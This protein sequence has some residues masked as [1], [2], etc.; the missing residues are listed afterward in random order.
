MT[1]IRHSAAATLMV[2]LIAGQ[3][4]GSGVGASYYV[5]GKVPA[6]VKQ[7]SCESGNCGPMASCQ[8]CQ[9][10]GFACVDHATVPPCTAE[11]TC[12][13][14]PNWGWH[15]T[16]WR[17]WPGTE[18]TPSQ[19]PSDQAEDRLIPAYE[20]PRPEVE[21]QQAPPPIEDEEEES[22]STTDGLEDFD[23]APALPGEAGRPGVEINLPPM[24]EGPMPNPRPVAPGFRDGPPGLPFGMSPQED[25]ATQQ[26]AGWGPPKPSFRVQPAGHEVRQSGAD[27]PPPLPVG[28]TRKSLRKSLRRLPGTLFD[29]LVLPAT[30][31]EPS[32]A[33]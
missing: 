16:K 24:P 10:L 14:A 9:R 25:E 11:G 29:N 17:R 2:A 5:P 7:A 18:E 30:A 15:Q 28:I 4:F 13:P 6:P 8:S 26:S 12:H 3:A 21:D 19:L 1:R 20:E 32:T 33:K 27:A 31:E 23:S 22:A